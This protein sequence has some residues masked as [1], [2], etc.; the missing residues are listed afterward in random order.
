MG[1]LDVEVRLKETFRSRGV[2]RHTYTIN[3]AVRGVASL[4]TPYWRMVKVRGLCSIPSSKRGHV[5]RSINTRHFFLCLVFRFPWQ[6]NNTQYNPHQSC[7]S[8]HTRTHHPNTV[9]SS[10]LTCKVSWKSWASIT[11]QNGK[12]KLLSILRCKLSLFVDILKQ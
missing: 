12:M 10:C 8:L 4:D 7:S 9:L 1:V 6:S 2:S 3:T 5:F 11:Y